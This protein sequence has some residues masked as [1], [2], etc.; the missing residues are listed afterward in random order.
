M[1]LGVFVCLVGLYV[2]PL[3]LLAWG[4][5]LRRRSPRWQRAFWGAIGG[6]LVAMLLALGAALY[7]PVVWTG[8]ETVR[9]FLGLWTLL[10]LP[11]A[12]AAFGAATA[13]R[14]VAS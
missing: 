7:L 11:L 13:R 1:T 10:L 6:H 2:M 14:S 8:D 4:H 12:G 9:G 5:G 3:V